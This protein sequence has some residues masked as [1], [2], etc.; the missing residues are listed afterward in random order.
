MSIK[1]WVGKI[2][3]SSDTIH[4]D[5]EGRVER[6]PW[7][8]GLYLSIVIMMVGTLSFG[9]GRLSAPQGGEPLEIRYDPQLTTNNLQ[10]TTSISQSAS[11]IT[12][13]QSAGAEV[14]ASS[15]SDKYHYSHCP[16]AKQISEAN[17]VTF[18]SA[19]DAESSGYVLAGNCK[20][21]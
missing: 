21:K 3:G 10:Q 13:T 11:A 6:F 4:F 19:S 14:V 9:L 20:P 16:G 1:E 7:L 2:K 5:R 12:A 18:A 17:K 15:K 8:Q